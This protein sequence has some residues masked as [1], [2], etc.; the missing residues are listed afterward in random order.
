[1]Q[2]HEM[3]I[4]AG[5]NE[6]LKLT[7]VATDSMDQI[8]ERL[9]TI[10]WLVRHLDGHAGESLRRTSRQERRPSVSPESLTE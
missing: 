3:T 8:D 10:T 6:P 7:F 5:G 1:M 9:G 2:R 4:T